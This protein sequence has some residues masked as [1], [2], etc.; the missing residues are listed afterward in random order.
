MERRDHPIPS[1][2]PD[3]FQTILNIFEGEKCQF[4]WTIRKNVEKFSLSVTMFPAKIHTPR[5]PPSPRHTSKR[6]ASG[7]PPRRNSCPMDEENSAKVKESKTKSPSVKARDRKRRRE[8]R[9]RK[10][11]AAPINSTPAAQESLVTPAQNTISEIGS[12]RG[13]E[14]EARNANKTNYSLLVKDLD[15]F[16]TAS[17]S[18]NIELEP[19]LPSVGHED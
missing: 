6:R 12:E 5:P 18:V 16:N 15:M 2:I 9:R 1:V 3:V 10:A 19:G 8:F 13:C 14:A 4:S 7:T 11:K 17:P